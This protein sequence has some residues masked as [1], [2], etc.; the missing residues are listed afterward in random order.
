M[1][2]SRLTRLGAIAALAA[3]LAAC[4]ETEADPRVEKPLVSVAVVAPANASARSFTGVVAARVSSDLGFRVPGKVV[5]RLV[6]VGQTVRVGEPLMRIDDTDLKLALTSRTN[7]VVAARATAVQATADEARYAQLVKSGWATKQRYDL[8]KS[9]MDNAVSAL[10]AA[11]ADE[12]VARNETG[13]AVL[14]ADSDGVVIDTLAEPGQVVSAGQTVVRL[15]HAGAREARVNLP[16]TVRPKIGSVV[17]ATLYGR[18]GAAFTARLRQL[19]DAADPQ[20]RTYEA[21]YVLGGAAA[22]APLG[23]TV[24]IRAEPESSDGAVEAPLGALLDEGARTG[25]WVVDRATSKVSFRPVTIARLGDERAVIQSG[26]S[27]GEEVVA[28]GA[29]LL[30]DGEEVRLPGTREARR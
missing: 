19:S 14:L 22:D 21:R 28:L 27:A 8:A 30:R 29:H 17:E 18:G 3:G 4:N 16:E 24:T 9:A 13:Y 10:N 23:A 2:L 7:A 15:A 26:V 25:V 11:V 12:N 6:D 5:E 20:T 1:F